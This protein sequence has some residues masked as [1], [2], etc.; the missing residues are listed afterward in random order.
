[1]LRS[2]HAPRMRV[3]RWWELYLQVLEFNGGAWKQARDLLRLL[4]DAGFEDVE[5]LRQRFLHVRPISPIPFPAPGV[6]GKRQQD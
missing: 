6:A 5:G 1:M 2:T 4:L 3:E